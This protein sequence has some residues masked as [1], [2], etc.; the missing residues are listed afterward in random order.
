[1]RIR[2]PLLIIGLF[3][4]FLIGCSE[5]TAPEDTTA[6]ATPKNFRFLGAPGDGQAHFAWEKNT[7]VDLSFYRIYR[8]VNSPSSFTRLVDIDQTQYVDRFLNYDSIYYYY[9]SAFDAKG[10]ESIASNIIDARPSNTSSPQ[11]PSNVVVQGSNNPNLALQEIRTNWTPPD[12]SDLR[13]YLIYR[14]TDSTFVADASSLLDSTN[15]AVY[16]DRNIQLNQKYFY[17]V[18]AVDKGFLQS[19]ASRSGGDLVL[20]TPVLVSPADNQS[21]FSF[22][23]TFKWES[24]ANAA[25]YQVFVG[26]SPFSDVIWA[27]AKTTASEFNY[28]GPTLT[29]SKVYYWWVG[30]YSRDKIRLESGADQ[31]ALVNSYSTVNRFTR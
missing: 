4:L 26:N 29:Q 27:S 12:I 10:N 1:M 14:G 11:Q 5:I 15:V 20:L 2:I 7:E 9:I 30:A 21:N 6:P 25:Q 3:S 16:I 23:Y 13:N 17:K 19:F 31:N 24:V 22:P 28:N 18:K 8:S